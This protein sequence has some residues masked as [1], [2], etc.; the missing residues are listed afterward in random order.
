MSVTYVRSRP[1]PMPA[2]LKALLIEVNGGN[3]SRLLPGPEGSHEYMRVTPLDS[4]TVVWHQQ[5]NGATSICTFLGQFSDHSE[6]LEYARTHEIRLNAVNGMPEIIDKIEELPVAPIGGEADEQKE[7]PED[8]EQPSQDEPATGTA[9]GD[10]PAPQ[11][12]AGTEAVASNDS[13]V[14]ESAGAQQPQAASVHEAGPRAKKVNTGIRL[15]AE[16]YTPELLYKEL[17]LNEKLS[18]Q[19]MRTVT[20]RDLYNVLR[21]AP[22]WQREAYKSL[23]LGQSIESVRQ[24]LSLTHADESKSEGERFL[25]GMKSPASQMDF[26]YAESEDDLRRAIESGDF[27]AWQSFLH[28]SQR[29]QATRYLAGPGRVFGGAGT[30]KTVVAVHRTRNLYYGNLEVGAKKDAE[31]TGKRIILTTFTS[32]LAKNLKS[33]VTTLDEGLAPAMIEKPGEDGI[34]VIGI[35]SLA[36]HIVHKVSSRAARNRASEK[37]LGRALPLIPKAI[38]YQQELPLVQEAVNFVINTSDNIPPR[39][40]RL[41]PNFLLS[42]WNDVVIPNGIVDERD[43]LRVPRAGRGTAL[44]RAERRYVWAVISRFRDMLFEGNKL[45]FQTKAAFA[46]KIIDEMVASG[47]L[48]ETRVADH[49]LIDEAQDFHA[50]HWQLARAL[51]PAKHNDIFIAED[52]HQRIYGAPMA[53]SKFGIETRGRSRG[54]RLNYRT[55]AENLDYANDMLSSSGYLNSEGEIEESLI[56]NSMSLRFGP[57]PQEFEE[58][59]VRSAVKRVVPMIQAWLESAS[60]TRAVRVGILVRNHNALDLTA[61]Y[62]KTEGIDIAATNLKKR[63]AEND[64]AVQ[65]LTMHNSKGLEFTH[66]VMITPSDAIESAGFTYG[67]TH[68]EETRETARKTESSLHYVAS[69]RA[70]DELVVVKVK[71]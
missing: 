25:D 4:G 43:Y 7:F 17:G 3:E 65:I 56:G 13:A 26:A 61:K 52:A 23:C 12:T 14:E 35:D 67:M 41:T 70:R 48:P 15:V 59:N 31:F 16:G 68:D 42:E 47:E 71:S 62:L 22:T 21:K 64:E 32:T 24:E 5:P 49:I 29:Y 11:D 36:H 38:V 44:N 39:Y 20:H 28:P 46:A 27:Q 50:G 34:C 40:E 10:Q 55:T 57:V 9:A 8:S 58:R 45:G 51:V 66:V 53:L 30:G 19:V 1:A 33:M 54:L 63:S 37:M 69:S 2:D 18:E 6:A 60:P